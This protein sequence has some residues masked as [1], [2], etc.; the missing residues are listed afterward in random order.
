[1]TTLAV[2]KGHCS[3]PGTELSAYRNYFVQY[4]PQPIKK[5]I[6][7]HNKEMKSRLD[8]VAHASSKEVEIRIVVQGQ[9]RQKV[10]ETASQ[11]IS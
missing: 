9:P 7:I 3:I 8:V 1:M 11:P 4:Q 10:S 6:I 5:G 2:G